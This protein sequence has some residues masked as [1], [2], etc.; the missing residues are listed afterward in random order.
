MYVVSHLS[1]NCNLSDKNNRSNQT[2]ETGL[3]YAELANQPETP[4]PYSFTICSMAMRPQCTTKG[5]IQFFSVLD[6]RGENFISAL[7]H[8]DLTF[9]F[10]VNKTPYFASGAESPTVFPEQWLRSC[11]SIDIVTGRLKWV[12]DGRVVEDKI[13]QGDK[14]KHYDGMKEVKGK[15]LLG[16]TWWPGSGWGSS[17]NKVSALNIF[18]SAL[19]LEQMQKMTSESLEDCGKKGDYFAWED[20]EWTLKEIEN[21]W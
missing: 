19:S 6:E 17:N 18:S 13:F 3:T 11:L 14:E 10:N 15:I 4:L 5:H 20:M 9:R 12:V 16:R 1:Q 2:K 8:S 21:C 7:L